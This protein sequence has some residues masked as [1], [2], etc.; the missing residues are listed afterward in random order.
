VFARALKDIKTIKRLLTLAEHE[1]RGTGDEAP[2]PEHLVLAA[3]ALPDRTAAAALAAVGADEKS[4]RSALTRSRHEA[5]LSVGVEPL[6][7]P[8]PGTPA[9][10]TAPYRSTTQAQRTFQA[11]S[12]L[13]K[14]TRSRRLLGAH[15]VAAAADECQRG[16]L[17][18][19][20][21]VLGVTPVELRAA[22]LRAAGH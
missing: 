13:S 2:G 3:L 22:A 6:D 12:K 14:T 18:R 4:L 15:V 19:A 16:T 5:L 7:E 9:P 21:R 11:A 1:A 8:A 17:A 20:L 10:G